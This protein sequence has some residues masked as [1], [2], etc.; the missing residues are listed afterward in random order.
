MSVPTAVL[1]PH[2]DAPAVIEARTVTLPSENA[3]AAIVT[4]VKRRIVLMTP[5]ARQAGNFAPIASRIASCSSQVNNDRAR[6]A[7][8]ML[9]TAP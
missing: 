2:L 6:K 8:T 4:T 7:S 3:T 5:P 1:A 9:V